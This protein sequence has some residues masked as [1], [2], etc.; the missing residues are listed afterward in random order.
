[1]K[2]IRAVVNLPDGHVIRVEIPNSRFTFRPGMDEDVEMAK[3][4]SLMI[5]KKITVKYE[6]ESK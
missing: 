5:G 3:L 1:M 6:P 2:K 4:S